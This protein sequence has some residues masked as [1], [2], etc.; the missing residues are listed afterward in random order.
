MKQQQ[1]NNL[2]NKN[3]QLFSRILALVVPGLLVATSFSVVFRILILLGTLLS[4]LGWNVYLKGLTFDEN[5]LQSS[6][7]HN[8]AI[9]SH[10]TR[11]S[12]R[13]A[14]LF[15]TAID[16]NQNQ[17]SGMRGLAVVSAF[18]DY[19][20][21]LELFDQVTHHSKSRY[22]D[23]LIAGELAYINTNEAA[24]LKYWKQ[25]DA[26]DFYFQVGKSYFGPHS[27]HESDNDTIERIRLAASAYE[28]VLL[29]NPQRQEVLCPA[30]EIAYYL[31][32]LA[33]A[34]QLLEAA[35][36]FPIHMTADCYYFLGY[37]RKNSDDTSGALQA[38]K[39][40]VNMA[41]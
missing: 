24:A 39:R 2:A 11:T 20:F 4:N 26:D 17:V 10:K 18:E 38:L 12:E 28:R 32:D 3:S 5:R 9:F 16:I 7:I 33:K 19:F 13:A 22:I 1:N 40:P 37:T 29:I 34:S 8:S 25:I 6:F 35:D 23:Y 15:T 27:T 31:N 21:S 36:A 14:S 30:G 41:T